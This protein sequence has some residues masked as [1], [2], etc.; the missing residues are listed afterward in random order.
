M[1]NITGRDRFRGCLLGLA[2]G[3]ALGASVEGRGRGS[4]PPITGM[5]GGGVWGL[6]AGEWTDDASMAL[7][8]A[9]SLLDQGRFDPR[10][11]MDKYALWMT[12]GYM[13]SVGD[14]FAIGLTCAKA[15]RSYIITKDPYSG[16]E[17]PM[18]AG[19][20]CI[21]RLAPVPMF[22]HPELERVIHYSADS[23]RTTH[24]A[25]E[26]LDA[27]R[28]FGAMMA[29][30]LGG[31]EK[32]QIL[33]GHYYRKQ[34]QGTLVESIELVAHGVYRHKKEAEIKGSGYVVESL[35]AAL[36]C[37]LHSDSYEEAVLK[38]VNLGDD[39]DTTA[40]VCGQLAGA[41]YGESGIPLQWL[42]AVAM[43]QEIGRIA[44][45]LRTT[46]PENGASE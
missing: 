34:P 15:I 42:N 37:F 22:Y 36:W 44:D 3:D 23:S 32:G 1:T 27:C 17:D 21:M 39:A 24:G 40:A 11:Q 18:T 2:C 38:A 13:S 7:C 12:E 41:Y 30:A 4:F 45:M 19:N 46:E 14:C 20:G 43:G 29:S 33:F 5:T 31:D 8:L 6:G 35:A 25:R 28:L 10:D 9:K 16:S 26:C